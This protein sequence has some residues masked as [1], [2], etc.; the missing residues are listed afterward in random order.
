MQLLR[1][2]WGLGRLLKGREIPALKMT[3]EE[4]VRV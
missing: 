3:E 1:Y 4:L 2:N